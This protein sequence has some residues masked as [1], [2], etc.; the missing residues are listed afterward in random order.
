[1][2]GFALLAAMGRAEA[3]DLQFDTSRL[4]DPTVNYERVK[5]RVLQFD[6]EPE[7]PPVGTTTADTPPQD[8]AVQPANVPPVPSAP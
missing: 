5:N 4:Y 8:A 6:R 3:R 2:A 1:V 7:P